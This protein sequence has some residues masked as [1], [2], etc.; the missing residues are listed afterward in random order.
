MSSAYVLLDKRAQVD[1]RA[2]MSSAY[3]LLDKRAQ[4]DCRAIMFVTHSPGGL[5]CEEALNLSNKRPDF[6]S[7]AASTV[8]TN[9][10]ILGKLQPG[11]LDPQEVYNV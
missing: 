3:V 8:S 9:W 1:C 6:A 10:D 7:I 11:S 5:A 4:V 2:I